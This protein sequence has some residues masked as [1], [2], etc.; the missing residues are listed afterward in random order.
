MTDIV[1]SIG[2][3]V[4]EGKFSGSNNY[5]QGFLEI[6]GNIE[7]ELK[8]EFKDPTD[9][10]ERRKQLV[11]IIDEIIAEA[12]NNGT[13]I[14][15]DILTYGDE[16]V[17]MPGRSVMKLILDKKDHE[18]KWN[19]PDKEYPNSTNIVAIDLYLI[20]KRLENSKEFWSNDC[21]TPWFVQ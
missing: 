13:T 14:L 10:E 9:V 18:R 19:E 5:T 2:D 20:L 15:D 17:E 3:T 7:F 16:H 11:E 1:F 12:I 8:D 6:T 21:N 4:I